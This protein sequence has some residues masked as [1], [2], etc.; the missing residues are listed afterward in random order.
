MM[1]C[2]ICRK[3]EFMQK[4]LHLFI[5]FGTRSAPGIPFAGNAYKT[6]L[7]L[8]WE[9][10][11][12]SKRI[13]AWISNSK[14]TY[15]DSNEIYNLNTDIYKKLQHKNLLFLTKIYKKL[16][17]F[18]EC[19]YFIYGLLFTFSS[20]FEKLDEYFIPPPLPLPPA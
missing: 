2:D 16:D 15:E 12:L 18:S 5:C 4:L 8:N 9:I 11:I 10:D 1:I 20:A 14:L 6:L 17:F 3:S 7:Y 19:L 13:I